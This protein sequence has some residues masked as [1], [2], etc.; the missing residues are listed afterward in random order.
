MCFTSSSA[1]WR[2]TLCFLSL[3][4]TQGITVQLLGAYEHCCFYRNF[5]V[6]LGARGV[7]SPRAAAALATAGS[8]CCSRSNHGWDVGKP[9]H[10]E[11][12]GLATG[13]PGQGKEGGPRSYPDKHLIPRTTLTVCWWRMDSS[14]RDTEEKSS[15]KNISFKLSEMEETIQSLFHPKP[16]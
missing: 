6:V 9:R 10:S 2:P 3:L 13:C 4:K 8:H 15:F 12:K 14:V 5:S 11:A 1:A 16:C 7:C